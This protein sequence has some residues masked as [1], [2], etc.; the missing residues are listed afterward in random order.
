MVVKRQVTNRVPSARLKP[1]AQKKHR[2]HKK[3]LG[4]SCTVSAQAAYSTL[5]SLAL[6]GA[7]EGA[8][9]LL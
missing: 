1:R 9:G 5:C 7:S 3:G 8:L 2:E 4:L 6:P